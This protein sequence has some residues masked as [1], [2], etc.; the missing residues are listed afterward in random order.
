MD[1]NPE[2]G[3]LVEADLREAWAHE[4][5]RF[6]PWLAQQLDLLGEVIGIPLEH[7]ESEVAVDRF[8]AD[9]LARNPLD[10]S[11]VLI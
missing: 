8:H 10:D 2:L 4:A 3:R 7:E 5:H 6:T 1:D 9:I 11:L